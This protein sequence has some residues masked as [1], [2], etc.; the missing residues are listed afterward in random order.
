MFGGYYLGQIYL[1]ISCFDYSSTLNVDNTNHSVVS[2][3]VTISQTH[4]L[5]VDNTT[6]SHYVDEVSVYTEHILQVNNAYHGHIANN[7]TVTQNHNILIDNSAH[8][9]ISDNILKIVDW[10]DLNVFFG[11]YRPK[12]TS[13]GEILPAE[14]GELLIYR[15]NRD[16]NGTLSNE[17]ISESGIYR[18]RKIETGIL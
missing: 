13:S 14:P 3:N 1:G 12:R 17:D 8:Q 5:V 10:N 4:I 18:P 7:I 15:Q 9:L 6:H 16:I 11:I 2:S